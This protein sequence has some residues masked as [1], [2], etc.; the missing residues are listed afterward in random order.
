MA[1]PTI[2]RSTDTSAPVLT[3]TAGDLV[4]L[5][6]K[7]LC[8][9]YG[10]KTAVGWTKSFTATNAAVFRMGGGNQFYLDVNDNGASTGLTGG[11]ARE[12]AVRGYEAMTAVATGTGDFPTTAQVIAATANW[13]KS[14]SADAT[15]RAW[16]CAADDRS[17]ILGILDNDVASRAKLYVF[18]DVYSLAAGD[19]YRTA[20]SVRTSVNGSAQTGAFGNALSASGASA[21][22]GIFI[23]RIAAGTGTSSPVALT[24]VGSTW[25]AT[26][27]FTTA[28]DGNIHVSRVLVNDV[29]VNL[30][31][32]LRGVWE[33]LT[34][35]GVTDG[36]T[37]TGTGELAGR[38]FVAVKGFGVSTALGLAVETTAWD[39]SS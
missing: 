26:N 5:L 19:A 11:T 24:S 35:V 7:C 33:I 23:A 6:D 21:T 15:A 4:N 3:G 38:S 18:G 36:D 12:A 30:R 27:S 29:G 16:F 13:R 2:F 17:F 25:E 32:W 31:G 39:T 37:W 20:I 22:A 28:P 34:P 8:A 14:S 9:G 10:S 1:A